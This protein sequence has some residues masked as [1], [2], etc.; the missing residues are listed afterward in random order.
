V[1]LAAASDRVNPILI[2][3]TLQSLNAKSFAGAFVVALVGVM[4]VAV[5]TMDASE[6]DHARVFGQRTFQYL[7]NFV[8]LPAVLL[9]VPFQAFSSMRA[10]MQGGAA[11]LLLLSNLTP[12][13]IVRGRVL[14]VGAQFVLWLSVFAPMFALTYLLRGVSVSQIVVATALAATFSLAATALVTALGAFTRWKPAAALSNAVAGVGLAFGAFG[15]IQTF[16]FMVDGIASEIRNPSGREAIV[17]G[18]LA[19]VAAILLLL[20]VGQ[21]QLTHPNENRSTPFRVYFL[22]VLGAMFAWVRIVAP[23]GGSAAAY[24][25]PTAAAVTFGI[26]FLLMAP[27]EEDRLSPRVR[28]LVP[29]NPVLALLV[30]PLLPGR[31]RGYLFV[32][33][34]LGTLLAVDALI[35]RDAA[36][37]TYAGVGRK[38]LD[39]MLA[40]AAMGAAYVAIF[41]GVGALYRGLFRAGTAG[42]WF[43][44]LFMAFTLL[45]ACLVPLIVEAFRQRR[46][47]DRGDIEWTP[48]HVLNPFWTIDRF[49]R[50]ATRP[51]PYLVAFVLATLAA[52]APSL[53]RGVVETLRAS[54]DRRKLAR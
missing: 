46:G 36:S 42:N 1:S 8:F 15:V 49:H 51:A 7:F 28:I 50:D 35:V 16:P 25:I 41:G 39:E 37:A 14:A 24:F 10:E 26:P 11:E 44:R 12:A 9:L 32:L 13:K 48:L 19:F 54:S 21:S 23:F 29:K 43:A 5:T 33:L 31:G 53:V 4:V 6:A 20:L 22:L 27:T 3:E 47:V 52:N 17:S 38:E 2:R 40:C 30:A 18:F 34:V 45:M